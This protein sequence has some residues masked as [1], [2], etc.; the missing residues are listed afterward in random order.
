MIERNLQN[1]FLRSQE[2]C[3]CSN[4]FIMRIFEDI[5]LSFWNGIL[6]FFAY[7]FTDLAAE[8]LLGFT[9]SYIYQF[10]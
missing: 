8:F 4:T 10:L 3:H 7:L 1:K 9:H 6:R 5:S 2:K